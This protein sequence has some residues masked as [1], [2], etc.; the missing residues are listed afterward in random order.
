MSGLSKSVIYISGKTD[1]RD[2]KCAANSVAGKYTLMFCN[3]VRFASRS[4]D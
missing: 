3:F 2:A 4:N 1:L